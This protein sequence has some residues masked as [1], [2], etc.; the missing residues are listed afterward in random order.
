MNPGVLA[1]SAN[2]VV[3]H[4]KVSWF[5]SL[6]K[7]YSK[8]CL[9]AFRLYRCHHSLYGCW[10]YPCHDCVS[11][12]SPQTFLFSYALICSFRQQD[13]P[14]YIN[15]IWATLGSQFLMLILL[16]AT[17]YTYK[18]RNRLAREGKLKELEG[19]PGFYYTI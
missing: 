18:K 10:R 15:G 6:T 11:I 12:L 17:T 8:C 5:I 2:N 14:R 19:Q 3:S 7:L 16:A 9:L 13:Y 4:S 1:Y